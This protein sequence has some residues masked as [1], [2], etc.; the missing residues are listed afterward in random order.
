MPIKRPSL[1]NY[2]IYHV[3]IRGV[4]DSVIFNNDEDRY[5][6]IFSIYEFNTDEPVEISIQRRKRR[7]KGEQFSD[8]RNLLVEILAFCFMPN[9]IHLL[10]RQIQDDGITK[11]MRK[12]GAGYAT[13]FNKKYNRKGHLFQG[14]FKA[15]H[16]KTEDQLQIVFVY[17]HTNPISLIDTHWKENEIKNP[18]KAIEFLE[19]YKWSSYLDY[20][21]KKNFPSI[22]K[23][24]MFRKIIGNKEDIKE[25]I[26]DWIKYKSKTDES[27]VEL[28]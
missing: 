10:L 2:E 17:I 25:F 8:T 11:F 12:F 22:I 5:R 9:H 7:N 1:V 20:I 21:D 23:R 24:D 13:Y 16:I 27:D 26:N 19:N 14:R 3:V 15:I 6:A 28:E 4:S 18:T